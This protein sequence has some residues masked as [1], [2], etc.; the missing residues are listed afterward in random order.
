MSGGGRPSEQYAQPSFQSVLSG[1]GPV[2]RNNPHR[3]LCL[4]Q[5]RAALP[6][7]P[8]HDGCRPSETLS[9]NNPSPFK[10]LLLSGVWSQP[11]I[12]TDSPRKP[13]WKHRRQ[14]PCSVCGWGGDTPC[15]LLLESPL[16]I[17]CVLFL[18]STL[19][20]HTQGLKWKLH[21]VCLL[22]NP[23]KVSIYPTASKRQGL[24]W[25]RQR[26]PQYDLSLFPPLLPGA[27]WLAPCSESLH[28][29]FPTCRH[30]LGFYHI[31]LITL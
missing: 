17:I 25:N 2:H 22:L 31:P 1:F 30:P 13:H 18:P 21:H 8:H 9:P 3:K 19:R 11:W 29:V 5:I 24:Y 23:F 7:L 4:P 20:A 26:V 27:G 14:L 15:S 28:M 16:Q 12:G 10:W 6:C